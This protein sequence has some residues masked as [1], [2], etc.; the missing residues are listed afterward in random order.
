[1]R[2]LD[3]N[4]VM[5]VIG[6]L[7]IVA[8]CT[9]LVVDY[10]NYNM[11]DSQ[12]FYARILVRILEFWLP[13][14]ILVFLYNQNTNLNKTQYFVQSKRLP[15][16]FNGY[17]IA[18][19][20]DF[21]NTNSK[22]IKCKIIRIL[23]K[24]KPDIIVITGDLIDSRRANILNAK[25]FLKSLVN[26]APVHYVLGN[27][28]SRLYDIQNLINEVKDA[29][30][31]VLR[32]VSLKISTQG[33][34]IEILGVDDPGFYAPLENSYEV[35]RKAENLL[36]TVVKSNTHF[37]IL[38]MHRPELLEL[39][40]KYNLDIVFAGHAHGGQ[41]RLPFVGGIVAPGQGVFPK[42]TTGIYKENNTQM[43]VSRG[44]GNSKFPFR[45]NNRP[46]IIITTL[47]SDKS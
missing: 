28:E 16:S 32:N 34:T 8:F 11:F 13:G 4:K 3:Y 20:S 29:G 40:S 36:N 25:E 6:V 41:I 42:Y 17:K 7:L 15:K 1:M 21:H 47:K 12:P 44:V 10:M 45:I 5:C 22:R 35:R 33:E 24:E 46:E 14:A 23:N 43:V 30:V 19:I 18:H 26:V 31:N 2:N 9:I 27:H 39:Y 37:K 38:L